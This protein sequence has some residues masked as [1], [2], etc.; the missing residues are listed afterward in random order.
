MPVW[1]RNRERL[2]DFVGPD[3]ADMTFEVDLPVSPAIA[4]EYLTAPEQRAGYRFS[5]GADTSGS[6]NGRIDVGVTYHCVHGDTLIPQTILDWRPLDYMTIL[7]IESLW[8]TEMYQK[9]TVSI[10]PIPQGSKVTMRFTKMYNSKMVPNLFVLIGYRLRVK[11]KMKNHIPNVLAELKK[12]IEE[13]RQSGR[14]KMVE[15]SAGATVPA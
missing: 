13:D 11:R 5:D 3:E 6:K 15:I 7:S 4:W 12:N 9:E 10:H 8:P 14:L 2:R 1:Q